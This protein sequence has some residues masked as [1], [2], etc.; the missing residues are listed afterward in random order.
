MQGW[1]QDYPIFPSQIRNT[2]NIEQIRNYCLSKKNVTEGFPFGDDTLVFKVAGK[3]FV[4]VNLDGETSVNLK[5]HPDK[6]IELREKYP[7]VS[8]GY[9]MNKLHWNTVSVDGSVADSMIYEWIDDSYNLVVAS[10]PRKIRE[11]IN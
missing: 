5:C 4:L 3:M 6:A 10:L 11:T 7:C 8:P 1:W 9:H 2:V